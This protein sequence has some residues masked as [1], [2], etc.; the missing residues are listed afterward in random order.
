MSLWIQRAVVGGAIALW[1]AVLAAGFSSLANYDQRPGRASAAPQQI[2]ALPADVLPKHRL[3]MFVHPRC[4]C[5]KASLRELERLMARCSQD[6]QATVYFICPAG[7]NDAWAQ[8]T[9][10]SHAAQIP[11]VNAEIDAGSKQAHRFAA[12]TSGSVVLYDTAGKLLFEGGITAARGH[13]G[14]SCGKETIFSLVRGE[15]P[16][17]R[18]C[19]VFGCSLSSDASARE[20]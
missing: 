6:V 13:E 19:P 1:L 11:G 14:D 16:M 9:L 3:L 8:G 18:A 17:T 12:K 10:W 15:M 20:R 7:E 2:D 5:S 4:S